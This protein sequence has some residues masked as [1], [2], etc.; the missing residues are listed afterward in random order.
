MKVKQRKD[1]WLVITDDNKTYMASILRFEEGSIYGINNGRISKLH[2]R[3]IRTNRWMANYDR[4]W[5]MRPR[6]VKAK[7]FYNEIIREYN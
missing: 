5:D 7:E 4:G 3:E 2:I 1:G 6:G